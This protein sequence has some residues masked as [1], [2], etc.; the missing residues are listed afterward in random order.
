LDGGFF[1]GGVYIVEGIP[2]SGKTV[3]AN[4]VCFHH[5]KKSQHAL[6]VTLLAESHARL[7]QHLQGL[8]F[9]DADAIPDRLTYVSGFSALE[10]EGLK[11]LLELVRKELRTRSASLV[12]LDGLAAVGDSAAS[13]REFK[14]FVHELQVFAGLSSCTFFLL[15]S[16]SSAGPGAIQPV[17]TMVDGLIRLND[18]SFGVRAERE[19][20]VQKF[21]GGRYL[22]GLH[23]FD[24]GDDGIVVYPRLE[25]FS[26]DLA[27]SSGA[28]RLS[29]GVPGIDAMLHGGPLRGST[30]MVLGPTGVGKTILGYH[31]LGRANASE[32]GL[33][34]SFYETPKR[35]LAKA[36][37][38]GL[39][40]T[41]LCDRGD[42]ELMWQSPVESPLDAIGSSVLEAVD[43]L[44]AKRLFIDGFSALQN[45]ATYP[46]RVPHFLAAL[47]REL[48]A[49]AVT[50]FYSAELVDA[51]APRIESPGQGISPLVENLLLMRFVELRSELH[52]V[53]SVIKLRDSD[54]DPA[55]REFR[56]ASNGIEIGG[57]IA[58]TEAILTGVA[59]KQPKTAPARAKR[60][61]AKRT[62]STR[63]RG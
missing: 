29:I 15:S 52:R 20:H 8:S 38:V 36:Q 21:R 42:V 56:I 53:V 33:L 59:H 14:K 60:P 39:G 6:Y 63:R 37:G 54:F 48:H 9:F 19:L 34:F 10:N 7:L 35:A 62:S 58:H 41:S 40:M 55:I 57:G 5:V 26:A 44:H 16:G 2:G 17:H 45:S 27:D 43:R 25:S 28:D 13:D 4:Q 24:I 32:K 1:A 11:A 23:T 47:G 46:E 22:R 61:T 50:T 51:F 12:V 18:H 3:L 31:F 49:R 30:T